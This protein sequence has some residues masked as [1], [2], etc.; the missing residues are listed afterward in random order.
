MF[1]MPVPG[2][3]EGGSL[4]H[5]QNFQSALLLLIWISQDS[6]LI[7]AQFLFAQVPLVVPVQAL[8]ELRCSGLAWL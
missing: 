5:S 2:Y 1:C 8:D 3:R 6:C 7:V 4:L